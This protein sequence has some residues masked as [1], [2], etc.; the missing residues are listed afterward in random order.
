[1]NALSGV[2]AGTGMTGNCALIQL[3]VAADLMSASSDYLYYWKRK[4]EKCAPILNAHI[5]QMCFSD[6]TH[7]IHVNVNLLWH[8]R[9]FTTVA[10]QRS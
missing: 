5:F 1:M 9:L 10:K 4:M 6:F 2:T 7:L 8:A 3:K